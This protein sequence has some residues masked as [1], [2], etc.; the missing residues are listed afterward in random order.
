MFPERR[1]VFWRNDNAKI[2]I[3]DNDILHYWGAQAD[4]ARGNLSFI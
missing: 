1:V 3:D 2:K 4:V